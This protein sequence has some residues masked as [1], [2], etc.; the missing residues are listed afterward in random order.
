MTPDTTNRRNAIAFAYFSRTPAG[1]IPTSVLSKIFGIPHMILQLFWRYFRWCCG[2]VGGWCRNCR[3][4]GICSSWV[5]RL[6]G[7]ESSRSLCIYTSQL[8]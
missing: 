6:D 5:C 7:S 4:D 2:I 3:R 1:S 8:V